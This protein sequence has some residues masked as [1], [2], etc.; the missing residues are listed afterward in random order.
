MLIVN[1]IIKF[2]RPQ[3]EEL[4][5][6][7]QKSINGKQPKLMYSGCYEVNSTNVFI[8]ASASHPADDVVEVLAANI[9]NN[10]ALSNSSTRF[11]PC[12]FVFA[13][14]QI[15][16][17]LSC[18]F[19]GWTSLADIY[20]GKISIE[21]NKEPSSFL[22]SIREYFNCSYTKF[23]HPSE[24]DTPVHQEVKSRLIREFAEILVLCY[25]L[26][27]YDVQPENI[28]LYLGEDGQVHFG[29]IDHGWTLASLCANII[30]SQ[31]SLTTP[32]LPFGHLGTHT[33][34]K[35][36]KNNFTNYPFILDSCE[37]RQVLRHQ[38]DTENLEKILLSIKNNIH[39]VQALDDL[40]LLA[41]HLNIPEAEITSIDDINLL[42]KTIYDKL[43]KVIKARSTKLIED[44]IPWVLH[45]STLDPSQFELVTFSEHSVKV[46]SRI[47]KI[48]RGEEEFEVIDASPPPSSTTVSAGSAASSRR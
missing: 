10:V 3:K 15:R 30:D 39:C 22:A 28:G 34:A 40:K 9:L 23:L 12:E 5:L 33:M 20:S 24:N 43:A 16:Y 4:K 2:T 47:I 21:I 25:L 48:R 35:L 38:T 36:P 1:E 18:G 19:R 45:A 27:D 7:F 29:K 11:A 6:K 37:F 8:K 14:D 13:P 32:I 17:V 44:Y 46:D 31:P 41:A 42:Q 26:G